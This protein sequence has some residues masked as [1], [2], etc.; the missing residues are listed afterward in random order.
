MTE[1]GGDLVALEKIYS[2]LREL[3]DTEECFRQVCAIWE[4]DR[5]FSRDKFNLTAQ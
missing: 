3:F 2:D 4:N 5:W 1:K